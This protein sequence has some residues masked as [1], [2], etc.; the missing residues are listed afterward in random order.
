MQV[1]AE[2]RWFGSGSIPDDLSHWF[3]KPAR[4]FR[5]PVGGGRDRRDF[6]LLL[7]EPELAIKKR[8][9]KPGLEVKGLVEKLS[10][11]IE[12]GGVQVAPQLFCKWDSPQLE[13]RDLPSV[14]TVKTRWLRKFDTAADLREIE[15]RAGQYLEDPRAAGERPAVGCNIELTKVTKGGET[16]WTFGAESFAFGRPGETIEL[17]GKSLLRTMQA[18]AVDATIDLSQASY[19]GYAEWLA[20]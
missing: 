19:C 2:V 6:Y 18:L 17:I 8:G 12:F 5:H 13:L 7:R 9:D 15:L 11:E 16:W 20:R 10:W 4:A 3:S 1:S 14:E